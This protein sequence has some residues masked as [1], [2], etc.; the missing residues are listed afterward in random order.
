[1]WKTVDFQWSGRCLNW[2]DMD[3][4][5]FIF[6]RLRTS[7]RTSGQ[8]H[9]PRSRGFREQSV[10]D[11]ALEFACPERFAQQG[12]GHNRKSMRFA[13]SKHSR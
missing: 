4:K 12:L 8:A 6:L 11:L 2:C 1:M 3:S 7:V 9:W 13:Y 10:F 5:T